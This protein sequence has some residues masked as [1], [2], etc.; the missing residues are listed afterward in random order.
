MSDT[1]KTNLADLSCPGC[2]YHL[3]GLAEGRSCPECGQPDALRAAERRAA[4]P[5][6]PWLHRTAVLFAL[7]TF[8]LVLLG[9]NVTSREAGLS[10][11]DGFT[12]YGYN[13]F[14]FPYAHWVGGIW[15]EHV[16]RLM[17]A[18]VGILAIVV[19]VWLLVTQK[20]R[21]W[22]RAAGVVTLGM[23]VLQGYLGGKRV[24]LISTPLAILHG[25]HG[26][27]ILCMTVLLAAATSR[28]WAIHASE[29]RPT[30]TGIAARRARAICYVLLASLFL[31]L[32]L[33]ATMR[34]TSA[35][36]A[37]PDFPASYGQV[38]PP[39]TQQGIDTAAT[40]DG[41]YDEYAPSFTPAQVGIHFAH[42]VWALGVVAAIMAA[43]AVLARSFAAEPLIRRPLLAL[44]M[45]T[46][47]QLALG[48]SVIWSKRT[49]D[50]A[51]A[52]QATGA[53]ILAV[54]ALTAFRVHLF[55]RSSSRAP[56]PV[57]HA[58]RPAIGGSPA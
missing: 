15:H 36:L 14:A 10:V 57:P 37:I 41:S 38:V 24:D 11:P 26:Q 16:H 45:L 55:T 8:V 43:V 58:A 7:A 19:M 32:T 31:Q 44:V 17:G 49:P 29:A 23:I 46:L 1:T 27:L 28:Y 3:A 33:G 2:G 6:H 39:F 34:H 48:A 18:S 30:I 40:R 51:T 20:P 50:L 54:A 21:L 42:R 35:G 56:L 25:I 12:V 5:Y 52:H 13:L 47:V 22:L 9:G 53:A 4:V